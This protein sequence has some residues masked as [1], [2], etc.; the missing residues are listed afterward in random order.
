MVSMRAVIVALALCAGTTLAAP[1]ETLSGAMH[2]WKKQ[3]AVSSLAGH[4]VVF[5]LKQNNLDRLE[6]GAVRCGA[7]WCD[8]ARR[9]GIWCGTVWCGAVLV[10][11]GHVMS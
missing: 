3:E 5:T 4:E 11:C 10:C 8:A 6:E 9:G 2:K 1:R 7:V